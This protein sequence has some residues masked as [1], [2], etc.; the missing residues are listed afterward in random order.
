MNIRTVTVEL[1]RAGPRHNQLLSP[2]TRYLGVCGD[3][4]AGVVTLPY[5]HADFETQL[6]DL[7]YEIASDD[8]RRRQRV[9]ERTG[10]ELAE[11]LGQIPGVDKVVSGTRDDL[12]HLRLVYSASELALLP[13]EL[14][15]VPAK[16]GVSPEG[17]LALQTQA[18]VCITRH[19]RSVAVGEFRWPRKPRILFVTGPDVPEQEH[20][21]ALHDA[22]E[23]WLAPN[24]A[25]DEGP[26]AGTVGE[27]LT[28][29]S[30][31]TLEQVIEACARHAYSHVHILAH[32]AINY[33][34]DD[35]ED[36]RQACVYGV[37]LK[38]G[39]VSGR[40]LAGALQQMIDGKVHR[41]A[42]VTLATCNSAE[43]TVDVRAPDASV[44][45]DLHASGIPIVVASQFPLSADGSEPFAREFYADQMRGTHIV[46]SLFSIRNHLHTEFAQNFHD[47]ASLVV[48]EALPADYAEQ[49]ETAHY[50]Q[51]RLA[52]YRALDR[53]EIKTL[54][55]TPPDAKLHADLVADVERATACLPGS[56][57]YLTDCVGLRAA[58]DKRLAEVA[59]RFAV[60]GKIPAARRKKL[61]AESYRRL[62]RA[63]NVYREA[64]RSLLA[65]S[66]DKVH[67]KATLHWVLGQVLS[68]EVILGRQI[69]ERALGTAR[70]AAET[71]LDS[72]DPGTRAWAEI[73]LIELGILHLTAPDLSVDDRERVADNIVRSARRVLELAGEGSE[74]VVST[75][76]Q[77]TRYVRWWGDPAFSE[78]LKHF[79]VPERIGWKARHGV[80]PTAMRVVEILGGRP[81][82]PR[83][84][85]KKQAKPTVT[86]KKRPSRKRSGGSSRF[87]IRM[88]PAENGDCLWIEYGDSKD[89]SRILID[90]GATS[91]ASVLTKEMLRIKN[92]KQRKFELFVLT[93]IDSDHISGVL[94]LFQDLPDGVEFRDIWF[95]GWRQINTFLS[96]KQG[97]DFSKL[98][99]VRRLP[100]NLATTA[101]GAGTPRPIVIPKNGVLPSYELPGGMRLTLLSPGP[102]QLR[103][104]AKKWK[105][106]LADLDPARLLGRKQRPKPVADLSTFDL[107]P[108]AKTRSRKD[109]S[110]ANGSSI[111]FL[112]EFDGRAAILTGDAHADVLASSIRK[113]LEDRGVTGD[114]LRID[115]LKLSHHGSANALSKGLLDLVD[116]PRYLVSSDGSQFY[117]PDREAIARVILWGGARPELCFNH[118]SDL[119]SLWASTV[120]KKRYRYKTRYP[121]KGDAGITVS[122]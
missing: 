90:C 98:L 79:G 66:D 73:S 87:D 118:R 89:P 115:A 3:S 122:L 82:L 34:E 110:E 97:E 80:V 63:A 6:A 120:L 56:G 75:C 119:N 11:I 114:R 53:I 18:P 17:W 8:R 116:C 95:N 7:R 38:D 83:P 54:D 41:P 35:V 40:R 109:S 72:P 117:H 100:W 64:T 30:G 121:K 88:L 67:R 48:Y 86:A 39:V 61:L 93:H 60:S 69:D 77:I 103:E 52:H 25:E 113:V 42:V 14:S 102:P 10:R 4:Q 105:K 55:P 65:S 101:R 92:P 19:V 85:R 37:S 49:L 68:L 57:A 99:E 23:P 71:D 5:Q 36:D 20:V 2:I 45:H 62:E 47:W 28:V 15:K 76:R 74:P 70:F 13:F 32:G 106:A 24:A 51:S 58:C 12:T 22:I 44:A 112:A 84:S 96:V 21:R 27:W 107:E 78:A 26:D 104:L 81:K 108:L 46:E 16:S 1:L 50:Y 91:A 31:A 33:S 9:L 59:F 43:Q 29:L 111:A 94:P